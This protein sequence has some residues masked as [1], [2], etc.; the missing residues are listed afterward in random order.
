MISFQVKANQA[1]LDSKGDT[2]MML[3]QI[4]DAKDKQVND[5][6][7][8]LLDNYQSMVSVLTTPGATYQGS[9]LQI[10][11]QGMQGAAAGASLDAS[12]ASTGSSTPAGAAAGTK[13]TAPDSVGGGGSTGW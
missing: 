4:T 9:N 1:L 2:T 8:K 12:F 6:N 11:A 5:L 7:N 10:V 3:N 13:Y